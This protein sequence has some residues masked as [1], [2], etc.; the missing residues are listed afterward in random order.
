MNKIYRLKFDKRR[1]QLVVV[2]ELTMGAGKTEGHA[3][4]E[5]E[6]AGCLSP[7][8]LLTG[9]ILGLLPA[10]V[11]ASPDLP[12]GGSIV[13]GK[14]SISSN[15]NQM[16]VNQSSQNMVANWNSFDIGKNHTVQFIQPGS[17][18]AVLNR[19]TG[20]HES[21]IL[22]TLQ[23]NGQVFLIN[24]NG[25]LFGGGSK[26]N[27]A[28]FMA[29]TKSISDADFMKGGR[30]FSGGS[31][32]GA[33][34]IN[35]GNLS[36][37]K[38]GFIVLAADRVAN[39][40]SISTP[41]GKAALASADS[42]TLQ[43]DRQGLT[44][45]TTTGNVV[46]ALVEN[47]GLIAATNG[48]VWLTAKGRDMLLNTV[49]NNSGTI[50]ATG[51]S[52]RGG[53][54]VLD[55]GDSGVVSQS[56]TLLADGRTTGGKITLEGANIHLASGSLTSAT[57]KQGG[58]EVY[59]GGGWQ[60]KDGSL[61]N[62]SKVVM[63]KGVRLDVSATQTGNG[64][65]AVLWSD[66]YTSFR[67]DI[68]ARG[69]AQS[70]NGG[71]VETS[72]H[73][74]LQAFGNV[75][76]SAHHGNSGE[77]LLD[78]TDVTIVGSGGDSNVGNV[79]A[80]GT[81][82]FSPT[83]TGSLILNTSINNQLNN[84][85]NVTIQT[86]G[87]NTAGQLGNITV[88]ANINKT[89]GGNAKL[90]L[91]ADKN[92]NIGDSSFSYRSITS[93]AGKLNLDLLAGKTSDD[94]TIALGVMVNISLNGGDL[95]VDTAN[96]DNNVALEFSNNGQIYGNDVLL[97]VSRGL[98]GYAYNIKADNDLTINGPISG[99]TGWGAPLSFNAGGMLVMNSPT[100]INLRSIETNTGG[101]VVIINGSKGISLNSTRDI[102]LQSAST[103]NNHL[104]ISSS[105]NISFVG[106]SVNFDG[107]VHSQSS[108]TA[109]DVISISSKGTINLNEGILN[110]G[111]DID[112]SSVNGLT[113]THSVMTAGKNTPSKE[114][115]ISL[116]ANSGELNLSG[117]DFTAN[118][119]DL[120]AKSV[121]T[122]ST[123]VNISNV[124]LA[125]HGVGSITGIG[126]TNATSGGSGVT[127]GNLSITSGNLQIIGTGGDGRS[128]STSSVSNNNG[129]SGGTGVTIT[130]I[131]KSNNSVSINGTG[132]NGGNIA[133]ID[134]HKPV[135][136]YTFA[137]NNYLRGGDAGN[138]IVLT[139]SGKLLVKNSASVI[140]QGGSG[141]NSTVFS[142]ASSSGK[143]GV[144]FISN[145]GSDI[146]VNNLTINSNG[147]VQGVLSS[148]YPAAAKVTGKKDLSFNIDGNVSVNTSLNVIDNTDNGG[149]FSGSL[150]NNGSGCISSGAGFTISGNILGTGNLNVTAGSLIMNNVTNSQTGIVN[151][152]G[153]NSSSSG[154]GVTLK[155][156]NTLGG[157]TVNGSSGS[158][159]G[160]NIEGNLSGGTVLGSSSS[161][162][163]VTLN[164]N[165]TLGG[166][167]VNGS[168]GSSNGVNIEGNLSGG[169]VLGKSTAST[170]VD[171]RGNLTNS[172]V[173]G[174]S[175]TWTGVYIGVNTTADNVTLSGNTDSG[176]GVVI[177]GNLA[178]SNG[179]S[180]SGNATG[181]GAGVDIS[182]NASGN[183]SGNAT[184]GPG[185]SLSGNVTN[186]SVSG[187][188][189]SGAGVTVSGNATADNVTINGS[190]S[191]GTG[192]EITGNLASSN[193]ASVSGN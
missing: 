18:A 192:V 171:V 67:G 74:N 164:G 85:T 188:A 38:G 103:G 139:A 13:A 169:T 170:G 95:R 137:P 3:R 94:S 64:G 56:G 54:I 24:P 59:V 27:T 71:R 184:S 187:N 161:G 101:G 36:V 10:M 102:N 91:L 21:Q 167:T 146:E 89:S 34:I 62:A 183:I 109:N 180:V 88:N 132:G 189:T 106:G 29:S 87:T 173:S 111:G 47:R 147:G 9:L 1:Q 51:M 165:I 35:Q 32:A 19:V 6:L 142:T 97:N 151:F 182:G 37:T 121:S 125:L 61:R 26:V 60:G 46:N 80:N 191:T 143:S 50:D 123:A 145:N 138:G 156:N 104:N 172:T 152:S 190:T 75:D 177:T 63:D 33:Q 96:K 81:D 49:V 23:A 122:G 133:Q 115:N 99:S 43:L 110:S 168:S 185:V 114:G 90:T 14:G 158:S 119:L 118:N 77:W 70:G 5:R 112:F 57:G 31:V 144:G 135:W 82:I 179:A 73:N 12:V 98:R 52:E 28:G 22:G 174:S 113:I 124:N 40:G 128:V 186:G 105:G 100:N 108:I 117:T 7:L 69:G 79:T 17:S 130:G 53:R 129:G 149:S 166:T 15:G 48:Q 163:G 76:S 136:L 44:S 153:G 65:T 134:E 41:Y 178:S 155:G 154:V 93:T 84:G 45:V 126:A 86:S 39:R 25:V 2:S 68:L 4:G 66:D 131:I 162:A 159:N 55:G 78:P 30:T 20:G 141:G 148:Q 127:L 58:G 193:G 11:L 140:G 120:Y 116:H 16:T 181:T 175:T 83:G 160:V 150:T 42:V 176:K 157:A 107:G 8:A 92:I 72:S